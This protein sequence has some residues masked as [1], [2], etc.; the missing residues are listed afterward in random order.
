MMND[1]LVLLHDLYMGSSWIRLLARF[2]LILSGLLLLCW[3]GGFPPW[4]WSSLFHVIPQ[5]PALWGDYGWLVLM[6][7]AGL[8]LLSTLLLV[9]WI[10]FLV[11]SARLVRSWWQEHQELRRFNEELV[12]AHNESEAILQTQTSSSSFSQ[13]SVLVS[14]GKKVVTDSN[15]EQVGF[16]TVNGR[17]TPRSQGAV[18]EKIPVDS[19]ITAR[20]WVKIK[21]VG[22]TSGKPHRPAYSRY[23]RSA[24]WPQ[25][26]GHTDSAG[27]IYLD[28]GTGLDVGIKR[29]G[30]PNEDSLSASENLTTLPTTP[31]TNGLFIVA[32]GMGGH[33]NGSEASQL[34]IRAM[35]K[36]VLELLGAGVADSEAIKALLIEGVQ[37]ANQR[38]YE[39]NQEQ[40]THMGTTMTAA[41]L[42]GDT[43]Y[44]A[45]VGDSRTYLYRKSRGLYRITR[46]HSVVAGLVEIGAISDDEVYTHPKRNEIL[47][48][49]GDQPT[50]EVDCF[51]V[52]VRVGDVVLLCSDGLWE[53]ARDF[54]IAE[55]VRTCF[56]SASRMCT[57]L[58]QAA[59]NRGGKDNISVIT[60][61]IRED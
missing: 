3:C 52:P 25:S 7:M 15:P 45:N 26:N 56:Q 49:L 23:V 22:S 8:L 41:L 53:M 16:P 1:K 59:L 30:S 46:D 20:E 47:R 6:P 4:A 36:S 21:D 2:G 39:R 40:N 28:I 13:Q 18:K 14:T 48:A 32:D 10:T 43:I 17:S 11:I 12:A 5:V 9:A 24:P 54:E 34:A 37:Y 31:R 38:V 35:R 27:G 55:I 29:R 50:V 44:V 19:S 33:G 60:V 61:C 57:M 42:W 51:T 58:I